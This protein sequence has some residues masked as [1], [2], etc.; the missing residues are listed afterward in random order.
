MSLSNVSAQV[1]EFSVDAY[2]PEY[3]WGGAS[4]YPEGPIPTQIEYPRLPAGMTVPPGIPT[5]LEFFVT[6][7]PPHLAHV[8]LVCP[9]APR[10][11]K[12]PVRPRVV[13]LTPL[14]IKS[15]PKYHNGLY[16][17]DRRLP[18]SRPTFVYAYPCAEDERWAHLPEH[19]RPI[20]YN[21]QVQ[22]QNLKASFEEGY[23]PEPE[24][25]ELRVSRWEDS[26]SSRPLSNEQRL[27]R[28]GHMSKALRNF[29]AQFGEMKEGGC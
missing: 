27:D 17:P 21:P 13:E 15:R 24:V 19:L 20:E 23:E 9:G 1:F 26:S 6:P 2:D 18:S 5:H 28:S 10:L 29:R 16:G 3:H 4:I 22:A 8:P 12:K 14:E 7:A 11:D 25:V